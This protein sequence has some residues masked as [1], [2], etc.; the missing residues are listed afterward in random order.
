LR[1]TLLPRLARLGVLTGAL[2]LAWLTI[3]TRAFRLAWLLRALPLRR[4]GLLLL[5]GR[6]LLAGRLLL[7]RLPRRLVATVLVARRRIGAADRTLLADDL[8]A[9]ALRG[10]HLSHNSL[11]A[12]R[13]L[14]RDRQRRR[15]CARPADAGTH[16]KA[17]RALRERAQ[18]R[19]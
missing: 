9:D 6:L 8:P 13:L 15:S 7:T 14:R 16:G 1:L 4:A 12:G 11:I 3:L 10:V 19:A 2:S 17:A 5:T 18:S